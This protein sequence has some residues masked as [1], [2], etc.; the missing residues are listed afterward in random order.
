MAFS[1]PTRPHDPPR[2]L[3]TRPGGQI[4]G[5]DKAMAEQKLEATGTGT[6]LALFGLA[7]TGVFLNGD[8]PYDV[9][10]FGAVGA[11]I[12]ILCSLVLDLRRGLQNAVRA[13]V[14]AIIGLYFLTLCE[15]L[16]PQPEFN[17]LTEIGSIRT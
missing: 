6:T 10:R 9:A 4:A 3:G 16:V 14:L 15:F 12:S 7:L 1:R 8:T 2:W 11:G 17:S 13:D 5:E